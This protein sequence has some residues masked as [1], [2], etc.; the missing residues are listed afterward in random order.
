MSD[1][2]D[3]SL[4]VEYDTD[5]NASGPGYGGN[6]GL[7]TFWGNDMILASDEENGLF[8]FSLTGLSTGL[9]DLE[10][11][12]LQDLSLY[13]NPSQGISSLT[14]SLNASSNLTIG[15]YDLQDRLIANYSQGVQEIGSH[16]VELNTRGFLPGIYLVKISTDRSEKMVKL[17]VE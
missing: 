8:I 17:S 5:P 15:I 12:Q 4:A 1:P 9:G 2:L 13:P 10:N 14:Y 16:R 3:I 6:F 11:N 7:Y